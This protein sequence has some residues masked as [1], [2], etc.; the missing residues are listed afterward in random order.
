MMIAHFKKHSFYYLSVF[1]LSLCAVFIS[2]TSFSRPIYSNT[3][4]IDAAR[5][6]KVAFRKATFS[7]VQGGLSVLLDGKKDDM[8]ARFLSH[9]FKSGDVEF[10]AFDVTAARAGL[11]SVQFG[12][13]H[14]KKWLSKNETYTF[15]FPSTRFK[16][17][18]IKSGSG[19]AKFDS[20]TSHFT[21]S[22]RYHV[23]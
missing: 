2:K 14:S 10:E 11:F 1:L 17:L 9:S 7:E 6:E 18:K 3:A 16:T 23:K 21:N 19:Y 5:V 15:V 13:W 22:A 8:L 20:F 12:N 4:L